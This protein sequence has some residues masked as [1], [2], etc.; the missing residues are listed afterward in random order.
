MNKFAYKKQVAESIGSVFG[1]Y[2]ERNGLHILHYEYPEQ[3]I[4]HSLDDLLLDWLP[5]IITAHLEEARQDKD[6]LWWDSWKDEIE[7]IL[8]HVYTTRVSD[9]IPAIRGKSLL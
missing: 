4:Y 5:T 3:Y 6:G 7:F 2:E 1:P 8:T 9:Q